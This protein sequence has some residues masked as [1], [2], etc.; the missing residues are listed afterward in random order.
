MRSFTAIVTVV[1]VMMQN[2]VPGAVGIQPAVKETDFGCLT[3]HPKPASCPHLDLVER[4]FICSARCF[5]NLH[6]YCSPLTDVTTGA[7]SRATAFVLTVCVRFRI[8][9]FIR[10]DIANCAGTLVREACKRQSLSHLH[11]FVAVY[12]IFQKWITSS[13]RRSAIGW[14]KRLSIASKF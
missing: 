8:E 6:G 11:D 10:S 1:I 2:C 12:L 3:L 9:G 7:N 4:A 13:I 5:G 14:R